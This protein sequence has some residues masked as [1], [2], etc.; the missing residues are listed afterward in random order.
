MK[1]TQ[2]DFHL[3]CCIEPPSPELADPDFNNLQMHSSLSLSFFPF[4]SLCDLTDLS[5]TVGSRP[6]FL[7]NLLTHASTAFTLLSWPSFSLRASDETTSR[8]LVTPSAAAGTSPCISWTYNCK[9]KILWIKIKEFLLR[10]IGI[11]SFHEP[12]RLED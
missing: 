10:K 7:V 9:K 8:R 3:I 1:K 5:L 2:F 11:Q 4:F 12:T 6:F